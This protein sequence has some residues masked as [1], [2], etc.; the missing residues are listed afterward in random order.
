MP[1][2]TRNLVVLRGD[3]ARLDEVEATL[4]GEPDCEWRFEHILPP[5]AELPYTTRL[6]SAADMEAAGAA[7]QSTDDWITPEQSH[8]LI[9]RHGVDNGEDWCVTRW[10]TKWSGVNTVAHRE[11]PHE[12]RIVT[13][14]AWEAPLPLLRHLQNSWELIVGGI[15]VSQTDW[16]I[17]RFGDERCYRD[18]AELSPWVVNELHR[19]DE[20]FLEIDDEQEEFP[21]DDIELSPY[22]ATLYLWGRGEVNACLDQTGA[23]K[24]RDGFWASLGE[25]D[26]L[27][28]DEQDLVVGIHSRLR[29]EEVLGRVEGA[30]AGLEWG[31]VA[32]RPE[33]GATHARLS[34]HGSENMVQALESWFATW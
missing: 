12:L 9:R 19:W 23:P 8:D 29:P 10:G 31:M 18:G 11:E 30:C 33:G 17:T 16:A 20:D 2:W 3:A 34:Q 1:D 26:Y 22:D 21:R 32:R 13:D 25:V 7:G 6:H 15:S 5:P 28:Q 24:D 27:Y 14:T 4:T